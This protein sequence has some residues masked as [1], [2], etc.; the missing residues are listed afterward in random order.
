MSAFAAL[1]VQELTSGKRPR[2]YDLFDLADEHG[3]DL[4]GTW[5]TAANPN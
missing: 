3:G 5:D 4:V 1:W 2:A